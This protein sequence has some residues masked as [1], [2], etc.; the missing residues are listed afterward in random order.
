MNKHGEPV[1][2]MDE[3]I[4]A[5]KGLTRNE[6]INQRQDRSKTFL[7][8]QAGGPNMRYVINPHDGR[9][10]DMR[11]M[12]IVGNRPP[13]VGNLLEGFQCITVQASGMVLLKRGWI[14]ILHAIQCITEVD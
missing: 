11:H 14:S 2:T 3:F 1:Y 8:S 12:L 9:V 7:G 6:I 4:Q 13:A 5:N 10:L